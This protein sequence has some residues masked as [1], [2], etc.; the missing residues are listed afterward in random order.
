MLAHSIKFFRYTA[1]AVMV[2]FAAVASHSAQATELYSNP[3]ATA[4]FVSPNGFIGEVFQ[5]TDFLG[6]GSSIGINFYVQTVGG[7]QAQ[8]TAMILP[9]IADG[10][11][12]FTSSNALL[13]NAILASNPMNVTS[14][15]I[16]LTATPTLKNKEILA[17]EWLA[18]VIQTTSTDGTQL[19]F[20][21]SGYNPIY[22]NNFMFYGDL[23]VPGADTE[24]HSISFGALV[25]TTPVPEPSGFAMLLAGLVIFAGVTALRRRQILT[26]RVE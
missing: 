26:S 21:T 8:V 4:S 17:N 3:S 7:S 6:A 1:A 24:D 14:G 12:F 13:P 22:P 9:F 25:S 18:L 23:D 15:Y 20:F 16:N 19:S 11:L 2:A 5:A 10:S